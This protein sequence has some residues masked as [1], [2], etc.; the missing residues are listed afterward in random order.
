M[1]FAFKFKLPK[2]ER[3]KPELPYV[4]N[5]MIAE[6]EKIDF[7]ALTAER[8]RDVLVRI[9]HAAISVAEDRRRNPAIL[10]D[11]IRL[12][13]MWVQ[14]FKINQTVPPGQDEGASLSFSHDDNTK[15]LA[16]QKRAPGALMTT[17]EEL[18]AQANFKIDMGDMTMDD[19]DDFDKPLPTLPPRPLTPAQNLHDSHDNVMVVTHPETGDSLQIAGLHDLVIDPP[20]TTLASHVASALLPP[21]QEVTAS[22]PATVMAPQPVAVPISATPD[23]EPPLSATEQADIVARM[24]ALAQAEAVSAD[25]SEALP[26]NPMVTRMR[27]MA[28]AAA[29]N[30]DDSRE[31]LGSESGNNSA[32]DS[33]KPEENVLT[34]TFDLQSDQQSSPAQT[35]LELVIEDAEQHEADQTVVE[36][37]QASHEAPAPTHDALKIADPE[38]EDRPPISAEE[39]I[40]LTEE[41]R[42]RIKAEGSPSEPSDDPML[43][44]MRKRAQQKRDEAAASPSSPPAPLTISV[45]DDPVEHE[46]DVHVSADENFEQ[47]K[48]QIIAETLQQAQNEHRQSAAP[49]PKAPALEEIEAPQA[50]PQE[51]PPIEAGMLER[52]RRLAG[53]GASKDREIAPTQTAPSASL[54]TQ[55]QAEPITP[56]REDV[57]ASA[58]PQNVEPAPLTASEPETPQPE[59]VLQKEAES[60]APQPLAEASVAEKKETP[61]PPRILRERE[62]SAA[63]STRDWVNVK[64]LRPTVIRGL[65]LPDQVITIVPYPDAKRLEENGSVQILT[66]PRTPRS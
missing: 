41:M 58:T 39:Q 63:P 43:A 23:E 9:K 5:P 50:Q 33:S 32:T 2:W 38:S 22:S 25:A 3:P 49:S 30:T 53:L 14:Y 65:P 36:L 44:R 35:Q 18:I 64:L 60:V 10:T 42:A 26:E 40:R 57:S 31:P 34:L 51:Q 55:T 45:P 16:S 19:M 61:A 17:Q 54:P 21:E 7:A 52:L 8:R 24:R 48:S 11:R 12:Q 29:Q 37:Q 62:A 28:A 46:L 56:A 20:E 66:K 47:I 15:D 27:A 4:S 59:P 13:H 6:L 1:K